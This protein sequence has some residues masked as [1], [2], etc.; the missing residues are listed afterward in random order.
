MNDINYEHHAHIQVLI[1]LII[2][3][4]EKVY[5]F[6]KIDFFASVSSA[7]VFQFITSDATL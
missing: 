1:Y 5:L 2:E 3:K 6:Q 7:Y 4:L